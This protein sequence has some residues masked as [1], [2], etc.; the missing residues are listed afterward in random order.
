[1]RKAHASGCLP[2]GDMSELKRRLAL[3]LAA[4]L[5][6][7]CTGTLGQLATVPVFLCFWSKE[8]YGVWILI[9][10]IPVCLSLAEAGFAT[11]A[12]NEVSMAVAEGNLGKA[13][14]SLQTAWGFLA[15]MSLLLLG[16]SFIA[17]FILPW[18]VWLRISGLQIDDLRWV[19]LLLSAYTIA[20]LSL[21]ILGAIYRGAYRNARGGALGSAARLL[22][23]GAMCLSIALSPSMVILS[24]A[25]LL[26]R[27]ASLVGLY[28]DSRRLSP[29]LHLGLADFSIVELKRIWRP[30]ALFMAASCGNAIYFQGL[31]LLV[32]GTLGAGAVVV[33]NTTR[34]LTRAIVQSVTMIKYSV[35]PEFSYLFGAGDLVRARRL[36]GLAFEVSCVASVGLAAVIFVAAPWIM[37]LWTHH[38]VKSEPLLLV[39][40]LLSAMLNGIWFVTSGL[41]MGVNQ[42]EGLTARYLLATI[43]SLLIAV[44]LVRWW[45]LCGV[46]VAMVLCEV[47]LLPYAISRTCRELHYS[48]RE[49]IHDSIHLKM[50]REVLRGQI[51]RWLLLRAAPH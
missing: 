14:R 5:F 23:L 19:L 4:N 17:F 27:T 30:S 51:T 39:L 48:V 45:G 43:L 18:N 47:V 46:A 21:G 10:S 8:R 49:L 16:L 26:A 25:M 37:P 7:L 9:S 6:G 36:N 31:T 41:L 11:A 29:E 28:L 12:A 13:R 2:A 1:M 50:C 34:A 32:G 33:F 35:L 22:E 40:F 24:G 42:H 3:N 15:A 38:V 20:G 44:V